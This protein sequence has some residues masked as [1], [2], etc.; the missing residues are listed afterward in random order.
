MNDSK[1]LK[2]LESVCMG[3]RNNVNLRR[4]FVKDGTAY[5]SDGYLLV[6]VQDAF[7]ESHGHGGIETLECVNGI[8]E[9]K[10]LD[11]IIYHFP[12]FEECFASNMNAAIEDFEECFAGNMN[13]AIADAPVLFAPNYITKALKVFTA[14]GAKPYICISEHIS[15]VMRA[16]S[17]DYLIRALIMGL[18]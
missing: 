2:A 13:A 16:S 6:A 14:M 9:Y 4:I 8:W 10:P 17:N 7:T 5:A 12:R 3:K 11:E 1:M 18:R 15:M